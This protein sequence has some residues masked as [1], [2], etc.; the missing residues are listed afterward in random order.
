MALPRVQMVG[1]LTKDPEL[2]FTAGGKGFASFTVACSDRKKDASGNW[3]DGDTCFLD[4]TVWDKVAEAV[5]E[6]LGKGRKVMVSGRLSQRTVE[7]DGERRTFFN[8]AADDVAVVVVP[9]KGSYTQQT[10]GSD[11]WGAPM[12]A[13]QDDAPPF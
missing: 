11:P 9:P 4:V 13:P 3:V 5:T 8:V 6:T 2:R 1:N 7:R 10:P 12:H